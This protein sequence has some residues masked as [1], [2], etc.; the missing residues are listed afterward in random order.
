MTSEADKGRDG[1][2][3]CQM[4]Q[5]FERHLWADE[6]DDGEARVRLTPGPGAAVKDLP[7]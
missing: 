4:A 2:I 3:Q 1:V 6:Y 7:K 5:R